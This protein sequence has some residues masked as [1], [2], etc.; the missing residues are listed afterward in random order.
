M[1]EGLK[2]EVWEP[3]YAWCTSRGWAPWC[4]QY[5]GQ[6]L[7]D[8]KYRKNVW[9]G[10]AKWFTKVSGNVDA[11]S[12]W[13]RESRETDDN[14]IR[15]QFKILLSGSFEKRLMC[16][17]SSLIRLLTS[18]HY[19]TAGGVGTS[20]VVKHEMTIYAELGNNGGIDIWGRSCQSFGG[21]SSIVQFAS[22]CVSI[23]EV[24]DVIYEGGFN[25]YGKDDEALQNL[26][27]STKVGIPISEA[28]QTFIAKPKGRPHG[29]GFHVCTSD[30][31]DTEW[32][33]FSSQIYSIQC[34]MKYVHEHG[35]E[36]NWYKLVENQQQ[37][38]PKVWESWAH[39]GDCYKDM[40]S[41]ITEFSCGWCTSKSTDHSMCCFSTYKYFI[42]YS[43]KSWFESCLDFVANRL[44]LFVENQNANT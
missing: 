18:E 24:E 31:F 25:Y 11:L 12:T 32:H 27:R 9:R 20:F 10:V 7:W 30:E 39:L 3:N 5:K 8:V 14:E 4:L 35:L 36:V 38:M 26:L 37:L 17:R 40:P 29:G 43:H 2:Y 1:I 13:A 33:E 6:G 34:S 16:L 28:K 42:A 22:D 21:E 44:E 15:K 41:L 19:S 23:T